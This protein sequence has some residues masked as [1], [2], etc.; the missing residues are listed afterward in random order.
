MEFGHERTTY[1]HNSPI[2]Y[3]PRNKRADL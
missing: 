2:A 1:K 3:S